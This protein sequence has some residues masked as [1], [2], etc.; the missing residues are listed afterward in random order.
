M[1]ED[2]VTPSE[3]T[4]TTRMDPRKEDPIGSNDLDDNEW[5]CMCGA[6]V[7][8]QETYCHHCGL[9]EYGNDGQSNQSKSKSELDLQSISIMSMM[10]N[11]VGS[12]TARGTM[13]QMG[14]TAQDMQQPMMGN[15]VGS[16]TAQG[17]M[18]QMG[19]TA[20]DMQ[21][22][23]ENSD[24]PRKRPS[25]QMHLQSTSVELLTFVPVTDVRNLFQQLP[26]S[27]KKYIIQH[28]QGQE[29]LH[30]NLYKDNL[31]KAMLT[32]DEINTIGTHP[33]EDRFKQLTYLLFASFQRA[34]YNENQ[35][36]KL[37]ADLLND[38]S[39][40]QQQEEKGRSSTSFGDGRLQ[41]DGGESL[42]FDALQC[43]TMPK[44]IVDRIMSY[45]QEHRKTIHHH[46]ILHFVFMLSSLDAKNAI[47]S[48]KPENQYAE[49]QAA[50]AKQFTQVNPHL[51]VD[52]I[53]T[54]VDNLMR[55]YQ[56]P[57]PG[58]Y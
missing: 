41:F 56:F 7:S 47:M 30:M 10:S 13:H 26:D 36:D 12:E 16:E 6:V 58:R 45:P 39:L 49:L 14:E 2:S 40:T 8:D 51:P 1:D 57:T 4:I 37:L 29:E 48:C 33:E 31:A 43:G 27:I 18:H 38:T 3:V 55:N 34:G 9:D 17:T 15:A 52:E 54:R 35:T 42:Q 21:Q 24:S 53:D 28:F 20:Q 50:L 25:D 22:P 19:E 46:Y 23:A 11:A 32:A 5:K 44:T